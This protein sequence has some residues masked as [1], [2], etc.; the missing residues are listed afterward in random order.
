[1][2]RPASPAYGCPNRAAATAD[3]RWVLLLRHGR[4]AHTSPCDMCGPSKLCACIFVL[5]VVTS[6]AIPGPAWHSERRIHA[7]LRDVCGPS[8]DGKAA[9]FMERETLRYLLSP[10]RNQN[11]NQYLSY[12]APR[13]TS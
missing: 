7:K 1:M 11:F 4:V 9:E 12:L 6:S 10:N 13:Y 5:A 2:Y 8:L 3:S